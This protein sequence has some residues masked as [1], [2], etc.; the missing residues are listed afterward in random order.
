MGVCVC[1]LYFILYI[2][3]PISI[4]MYGVMGRISLQMT[5]TAVTP[6]FISVFVLGDVH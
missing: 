3:S 1:I 2:Y 4:V 5:L 6:V